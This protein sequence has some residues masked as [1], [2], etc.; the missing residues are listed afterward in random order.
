MDVVAVAGRSI[1]A[2]AVIIRD[3]TNTIYAAPTSGRF[4]VFCQLGLAVLLIA[5]I[6]STVHK[7]RLERRE[8]VLIL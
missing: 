2:T 1:V 7:P 6:L 3:A 4:P 8:Q 5:R